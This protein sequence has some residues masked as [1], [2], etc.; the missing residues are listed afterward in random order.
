MADPGR[1]IIFSGPSGAGKSTVTRKILSECPLPLRLSVSATTRDAR[2][3]EKDGIEY[4]F[5]EEAE[6]LKLR[7]ADEFLE[8]KEVF[9]SNWYGTLRREVTDGVSEGIWV[10]LEIDV[11]GAVSVMEQPW[12]DPISFFIHPGSPR[13]LERRLRDRGT[14]SEDAI[15]RRLETAAN[16]MEYLPRYQYEIINSSVDVA[17]AQICQILE[18]H[19]ENQAC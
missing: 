16:E 9:G 7:D 10:I 6:F 5:L 12:L 3:G 13:E 8:C 19:K 11:Q 18:D 14:E 15:K 2:P 17:A 1:L 4:H